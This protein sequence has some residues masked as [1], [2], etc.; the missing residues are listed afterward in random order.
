[1][2]LLYPQ[3]DFQTALA[4]ATQLH[5]MGVVEIAEQFCRTEHSGAQ[6][7]A[8]GG[9]RTTSAH[10][11]GIREELVRYAKEAGYPSVAAEAKKLWFDMASAAVL[12]SKMNICLGEASKP[13]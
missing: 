12:H 13:G 9:N 1:M 10:L 5:G 4:I 6:F 7:T 11:S 2:S 3:I 8:V